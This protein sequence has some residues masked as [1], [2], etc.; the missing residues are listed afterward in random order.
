MDR[1]HRTYEADAG[2]GAARWVRVALECPR[3]GAAELAEALETAGAAAVSFEDAGDEPQFEPWPADLR[4]WPTVRVC[5]LFSGSADRGRLARHVPREVL[6]RAEVSA[7]PDADWVRKGRERFGPMRFGGGRLRVCP[8]WAEPEAQGGDAAAVVRLDPGLAFGTGS[9]PSTALCLERLAGLD[10]AGRGLVV[11][12][13]CGSGIL[14]IAAL[15]LGAGRCLAVD[16]DPRALDAA[17]ANAA[18]N[19]VAERFEALAPQDLPEALR[20]QDRR[21]PAADVLAANIVAGPLAALAGT[22]EGLLAPGGE[23]MLAGIL[24]AQAP[25]LAARYAPWI[26]LAE[27]AREDGWALLA[28]RR[29]G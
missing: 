12:Y 27:A 29:D 4:L 11:D 22:F 18:R 19:G 23:L 17:R 10:L 21:R 26:R 8:T 6:E 1:T 5:G 14:G 2:G 24:A 20:R 28:G 13:G 9:H 15:R 3:H 16:V 7:L 25:G